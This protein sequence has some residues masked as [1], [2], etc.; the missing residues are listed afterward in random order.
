M[1]GIKNLFLLLGTAIAGL[2]L[3][4]PGAAKAFFPKTQ[5]VADKLNANYEKLGSWRVHLQLNGTWDQEIR[6]WRKKNLWRQEW[7]DSAAGASRVLRAGVGSGRRISAVFPVS[8][9]I[10][11]PPLNLDWVSAPRKEWRS[12]EIEDQVKSYQFLGDRPCIVLGAKYGQSERSQVWIDLERYVPLRLIT[13]S[14]I[15]WRWAEYYS[16]GNHLLPTRLIIEF[17]QGKRFAFD[18][19]WRQVGTEI[20]RS[21]FSPASI[22]EDFGPTD[23]SGL[24]DPHF[25]FL[26]DNLP[27]NRA[28]SA[29]W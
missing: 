20:S 22:R 13:P 3:L 29:S 15:I 10:P 28:G 26:L 27:P 9:D 23:E 6:C 7:V 14:G 11:F 19:N 5:E 18:L 25:R 16:L 4:H 12:L 1:P 24:K 21:R 17:P 2:L 8:A